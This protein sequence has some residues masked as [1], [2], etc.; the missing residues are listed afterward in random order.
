MGETIGEIEPK[1]NLEMLAP[2]L[3]APQSRLSPLG[4]EQQVWR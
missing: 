4:R 1:S 3:F 2:R